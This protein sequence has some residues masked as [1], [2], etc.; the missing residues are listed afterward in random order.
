MKQR[1]K[2]VTEEL[3]N[4]NIFESSK[5]NTSY[6]DPETGLVIDEEKGPI[7]SI[8][9]NE[10]ETDYVIDANLTDEEI[11]QD[12]YEI[13]TITVGRSKVVG[14]KINIEDKELS[15]IYKGWEYQDELPEGQ[16]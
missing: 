3:Y 11:D 1:K 8:A 4:R 5:V 16:D 12:D 15:E 2:M 9:F 13:T 14:Q 6:F 7:Y 10:S